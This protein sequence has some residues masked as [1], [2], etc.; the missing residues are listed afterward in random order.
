MTFRNITNCFLATTLLK[1]L[2]MLWSPKTNIQ[3]VHIFTRLSWYSYTKKINVLPSK[4]HA[5]CKLNHC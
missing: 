4:K 2:N 3:I 5:L 1:C